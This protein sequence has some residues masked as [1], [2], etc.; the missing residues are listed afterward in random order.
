MIIIEEPTVNMI[1]L[2]KI[3]YN[4]HICDEVHLMFKDKVDVEVFNWLNGKAKL[5]WKEK[6]NNIEA[7]V[8]F[9]LSLD[10]RNRAIA[11]DYINSLDI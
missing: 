3:F 1:N 7:W 2:L 10:R 4:E 5:A 9:F 11:I 8:D 6:E